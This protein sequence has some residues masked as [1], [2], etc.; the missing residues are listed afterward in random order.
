MQPNFITNTPLQVPGQRRLWAT[1]LPCAGGIVKLHHANPE[2]EQQT[3]DA[4]PT[5]ASIFPSFLPSRLSAYT[6]SPIAPLLAHGATRVMEPPISAAVLWERM[7][8]WDEELR[9]EKPSERPQVTYGALLTHRLLYRCPIL[10]TVA[11]LPSLT[12]TT[13]RSAYLLEAALPPVAPVPVGEPEKCEHIECNQVF[14]T[15]R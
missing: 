13:F 7:A 9:G 10:V 1:A 14:A 8:A 3:G 5:T 12:S 15:G 4:G 11:Y 2:R 6:A